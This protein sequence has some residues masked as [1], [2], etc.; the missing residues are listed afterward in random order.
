MTT[1]TSVLAKEKSLAPVNLIAT[2]L[3]KCTHCDMY[4]PH[5]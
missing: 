5:K 1:L 3:I 2:D 4:I